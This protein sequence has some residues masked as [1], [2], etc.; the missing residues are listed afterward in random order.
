MKLRLHGLVSVLSQCHKPRQSAFSSFCFLLPTYQFPVLYEPGMTAQGGPFP[1][2][3]NTSIKSSLS[4]GADLSRVGNSLRLPTCLPRV[5]PHRSRLPINCGCTLITL[6]VLQFVGEKKEKK[7]KF[8]FT[9]FTFPIMGR[10]NTSGDS[11]LRPLTT[12]PATFSL[13]A[14]FIDTSL[15]SP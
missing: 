5:P 14:L 4:V 15:S 9:S 12:P 2:I 13:A 6:A 11:S 1:T 7:G 10:K 8:R 3:G